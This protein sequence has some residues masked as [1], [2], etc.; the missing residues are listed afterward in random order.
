M[1]LELV[2]FPHGNYLIRTDRSRLDHA[3]I[4]RYLSEDSYWAKGRPFDV[5]QPAIENSP[6]G[7][8]MHRRGQ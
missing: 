3:T 4:H 5:Q 6:L 2:E 7:R 1:E 8:W